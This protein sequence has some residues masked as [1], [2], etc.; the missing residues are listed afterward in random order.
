MKSICFFGDSIGKG[1]MFDSV[2]NKYTAVKENFANLFSEKTMIPIKNNSYFGCTVTKGLMR[3]D[4]NQDQLKN[5]DCVVFQFGGNDSDFNW[6]EIS[7]APDTVHFPRTEYKTF[8]N[9]YKTLIAKA[10]D[11]GK[12]IFILN[13]PP[14]EH[15]KYFSW[16]CNGR[17][18]E[19]ILKWLGGASDY[20][21]R[22]H[23]R[24]N[25]AMNGIVAAMDVPLVDIRSAFLEKRNYSDYF[26]ID[27]IH[28]NEKG[29][30]LIADVLTENYR[31]SGLLCEI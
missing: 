20:I 17:C 2:K 26:C 15:N 12:Q 19:N 10:K 8:I 14:V 24:Y 25:T 18:A 30:R 16:I 6:D 3:F 23:E 21:Y 29:H 31:K 5:C 11:I 1:V 13:L 9:T 7:I 4:Q 27:G 28:P 22:W